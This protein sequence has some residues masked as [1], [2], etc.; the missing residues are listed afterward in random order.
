MKRIFLAAAFM[1]CVCAVSASAQSPRMPPPPPYFPERANDSV[2]QV[3]SDARV[4]ERN[5]T[6]DEASRD[7]RRRQRPVK[8]V[9]AGRVVE[10]FSEAQ[11]LVVESEKTRKL[12]DVPL[13]SETRLMAEGRTEAPG[14]PAFS[15]ADFKP[16]QQVQIIYETPGPVVRVVRVL[17]PKK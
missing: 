6:R 10:V 15:V 4:R 12:Y 2:G 17:R 1:T 9:L 7:R 11:R 13:T 3:L 16:G 5:A 14:Q 8:H